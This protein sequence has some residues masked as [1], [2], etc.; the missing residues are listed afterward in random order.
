LGDGATTD[1]NT[2]TGIGNDVSTHDRTSGTM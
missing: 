1:A 2:T